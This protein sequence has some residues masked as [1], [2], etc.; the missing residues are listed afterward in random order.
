MVSQFLLKIKVHTFYY[1]YL[2]LNSA[3]NFPVKVVVNII[4][5]FTEENSR[6]RNVTLKHVTFVECGLPLPYY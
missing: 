5:G 3:F 6:I 2:A 1:T 4:K